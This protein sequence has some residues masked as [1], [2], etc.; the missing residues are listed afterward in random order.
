[1]P[2][3]KELPYLIKIYSWIKGEHYGSLNLRIL[4][5]CGTLTCQ[6]FSAR[7]EVNPMNQCYPL[8]DTPVCDELVELWFRISEVEKS[9]SDSLRKGNKNVGKK[10]ITYLYVCVCVLERERERLRSKRTNI[11][12][13]PMNHC[14]QLQPSSFASESWAFLFCLST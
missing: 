9:F 7:F 14:G 4:S 10:E 2:L 11:I 1:M 8:L 12:D 6:R 3:Y 5:N 13:K